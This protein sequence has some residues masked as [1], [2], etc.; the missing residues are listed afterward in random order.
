MT[1]GTDTVDAAEKLC[2]E[3]TKE[4]PRV[5][6]FGGKIIFQREHWYH[7]LLH[8]ETAFAIQKRLQWAGKTM[9][10]LPAKVQ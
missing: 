7:R 10:I 1:I 5:T 4:F 9:V 3:I 2:M 6:F 8:N